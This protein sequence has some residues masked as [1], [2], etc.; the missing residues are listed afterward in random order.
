[1]R[2]AQLPHIFTSTVS[3]GKNLKSKLGKVEEKQWETERLRMF[4]V[5]LNEYRIKRLN[6]LETRRIDIPENHALKCSLPCL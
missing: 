3:L 1:M 4:S 6:F 2:K 5:S